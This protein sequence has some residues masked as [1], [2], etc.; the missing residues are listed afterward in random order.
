MA[1]LLSRRSFVHCKLLVFIVTA[2][3]VL[4][5]CCQHASAQVGG[6]YID[7]GGVLRQTGTLAPDARLRLLRAA[8]VDP[9]STP[10]LGIGSKLRMISLRRLQRTVS[11]LHA[12]KEPLPAAVRYLAGLNRVQYLFF[13]PEENDVVI[14]G[15]AEGW[16]QLPT[17]EVVGTRSNRPV[18]H[19][20]DFIA[21]LRHSFAQTAESSFIGCSIEPTPQG[22]QNYAAYMRKLGNHID[23][24][25]IRQIFA[26]ME[27]SMGP[28]DVKLYGIDPSS[29]LALKMVAADHWPKRLALGHDASPVRKVTNYMDL[30]ARRRIPRRQQKIRWWFV[31]E[32][33]AIY[34]TPDE[35]A[36]QLKGQGVKVA[37]AR[38]FAKTDAH[39]TK[40]RKSNASARQFANS[41]TKH[42]R[43]IAARVPVFAELQNLIGLSVAAELIAQKS[44][45]FHEDTTGFDDTETVARPWTPTTFLD[46]A[47]CPIEE[48]NVP[49]HVPSL[50][51]YRFVRGRQ[52][53]ITVSGGVEINLRTLAGRKFRKPAPK[54]KLANAREEHQAP[55]DSARWWWD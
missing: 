7:A 26:G 41:F 5:T 11:A 54:R 48:L 19:L 49:S 34:H 18:L 55:A 10:A 1:R 15:P 28:Q 47:A 33:D 31:G 45:R 6:V 20:D 40:V 13:Y 42:F 32:F 44:R 2:G 29:P 21:A 35:L 12:K 53:L 52:W 46:G 27:V 25:R 16:K 23:R 39:S 22:L 36:F 51:N 38:L 43:T 50:A 4:H 3:C 37:T 30:A 17:G 14:A 8:S 24:S 9:P